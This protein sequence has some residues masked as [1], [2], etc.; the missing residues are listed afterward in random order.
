MQDSVETNS[1]SFTDLVAYKAVGVSKP[2]PRGAI[3]KSDSTERGAQMSIEVE[4]RGSGEPQVIVHRVRDTVNRIE[5][6][7]SCGRSTE[8]QLEYDG[9]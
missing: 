6:V 1:S 7:C 5:I 8:I 9:D 2:G 4:A 3:L